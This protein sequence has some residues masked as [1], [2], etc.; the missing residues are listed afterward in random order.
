MAKFNRKGKNRGAAISTASLP[1]IIFMLLFFFM[2][3]TV[4]RDVEL[5]VKIEQPSATEIVKLENKSMVDYIYVGQPTDLS[6]GTAPRI[7]LND[8]FA[9]L[10]HI[11]AFVGKGREARDEKLHGLIVTSLKVDK[12]VKMGIITDIKEELRKV[13]ALK[14]NYSTLE[15]SIHD[16]ED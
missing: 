8:A 10:S 14:I 16:E 13:Q 6:L 15:G 4:M 12:A 3:T 7:Q 2:V 9:K 5:I 1:D 11:E